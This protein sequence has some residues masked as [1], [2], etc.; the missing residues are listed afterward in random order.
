MT[1]DAL[2]VMDCEFFP[3]IAWFDLF[4]SHNNIVLEQYEHF[5]KASYRNRT[6]I[7]GPNGLIALSV[8]LERGRNQRSIMKDV[9]ICNDEKWQKLHWKSLEACYRRSAYFEYYEDDLVFLFEKKYDYLVDYNIACLEGVLQLLKK[10]KKYN[11]STLYKNDY[12]H[13]YRNT[14]FP[15]DRTDF[16]HKEYFQPF[17]ERNGFEYNLSILDYLFCNGKWQE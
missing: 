15:K 11:L 16:K 6:Y 9:K 10:E 3:C 8:P 7:A 13:D 5:V 12:L 14:F 4:F 17:G 2:I 1:N